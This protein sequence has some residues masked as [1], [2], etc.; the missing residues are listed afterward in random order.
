MEIKIKKTNL[1]LVLL[2]LFGA[3]I[4]AISASALTAEECPPSSYPKNCG[5]SPCEC[6]CWKWDVETQMEVFVGY[7]ECK[8]GDD[9][10][11]DTTLTKDYTGTNSFFLEKEG[12]TLDCNGHTL[13]G[14]GVS[15]WYDRATIKN[16][17]IVNASDV[18]IR[19]SYG[20]GCTV[21]DNIVKSCKDDGIYIIHGD[22]SIIT[23]NIAN[24]NGRNG[25]H[26]TGEDCVIENNTANLNKV[27]GFSL[28]GHNSTIIGN[29][30][31]SNNQMGFEMLAMYNNTITNNTANVNGWYG[32]RFSGRNVTLT[33]NTANSNGNMGFFLWSSRENTLTNNTANSNDYGI[34]LEDSS[35]ENTIENNS[36]SDNIF[37][38]YI[39]KDISPSPYDEPSVN[40][41]IKSNIISNNL[42][43]GIKLEDSSSNLIYNNYFNN[44]NNA[45][46][47]ENNI[48][49]ITKTLGT[50]IVGGPYLG[51]NYWSDYYGNDL[52]GDG[53]GD[54]EIPYTCSGGIKQGG[55]YLPLVCNPTVILELDKTA[56]SPGD[57]MTVT[58]TFEN[59]CLDDVDTYFVQAV[60]TVPGHWRVVNVEPITL[61]AQ[62]EES[63]DYYFDIGDWGLKGFDAQYGVALLFEMTK[64]YKE[65]IISKDIA[66]WRYV[67]VAG[68]E[69]QGE[70]EVVPEEIVSEIIESFGGTRLSNGTISAEAVEEIMGNVEK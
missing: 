30:A 20:A 4:G 70:M 37:G 69:A 42:V 23:G 5:G 26:C 68:A 29:T 57:T 25:I 21:K 39:C 63:H 10:V 59:P 24:L 28:G 45:Y 51:G 14:G 12:I 27:Y 44:S 18:G 55:D 56:Y 65:K 8:L 17:V 3:F 46:D 19:T 60:R 52:D 40:N 33:N 1:I 67:P 53:L 50:N 6:E 47:Y 64:P 15:A 13:N 35:N 66:D 2:I 31:N 61:P 16:C 11:K 48:W 58:V 32:I 49:N 36:V 9:L 41:T 34:Y 22:N 7:R 62:S 38:I 54:T 43:Y